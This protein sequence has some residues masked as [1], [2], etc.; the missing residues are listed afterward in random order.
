MTAYNLKPPDTLSSL[1]WQEAR[2]KRRKVLATV[3]E[4]RRERYKQFLHKLK[5]RSLQVDSDMV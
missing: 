4:R 5:S 3:R 2:E 1:A